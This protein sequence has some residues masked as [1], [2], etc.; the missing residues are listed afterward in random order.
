MQ[1]YNSLGKEYIDNFDKE[2]KKNSKIVYK[3]NQ[4]AEDASRGMILRNCSGMLVHLY[5]CH[6][7]GSIS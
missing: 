3:E 7:P 2:L 4:E 5:Q 1:T 6:V